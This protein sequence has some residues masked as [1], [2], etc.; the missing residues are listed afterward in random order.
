MEALRWVVCYLASSDG[1]QKIWLGLTIR[2]S[3]DTRVEAV[4][5]SSEAV[6]VGL[7]LVR[8]VGHI[9][10]SR[11]WE[12]LPSVHTPISSS[13][14]RN[15]IFLVVDKL[16]V[17]WQLEQEKDRNTDQGNVLYKQCAL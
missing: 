14:L 15:R 8:R 12:V 13:Q 9:R 16:Q 17:L 3:S 2:H 10:Y 4:T 6:V 11:R 1:R 7:R 5:N